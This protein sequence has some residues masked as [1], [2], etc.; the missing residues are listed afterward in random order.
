[1]ARRLT[2]DGHVVRVFV[3]GT[4]D[5][6]VPR[7]L[8]A[9]DVDFE[10]IP[11]MGRS[12]N[13][14]NDLLAL[15]S[16]RRKV[17]EFSPDL[18]STHASKAGALGRIACAG[19]RVPVL[20]TP[21]CWS[22]T[23]GFPN[24]GIYLWIERLLAPLASR[25]ITV[26]E[27]ERE[28]GLDRGVGKATR[29]IC[30]HN[31]V[32]DFAERT[33]RAAERRAGSILM[34]A[35]FE[36]QKDQQLLLRAMA[37]NSD[38]NWNLT[39]VGDGPHRKECENLA[40][41]LD[42]D[43]RVT[44]AG[45]SDQVEEYLGRC[46]IFALITHWEGFPRSILEAMRAGLPVVVSNVGGCRESVSDGKTGRV[47]RHGDQQELAAAIRELLTDDERREAMG[48]HALQQYQERFTFEVMYQKY[49]DLYR[50][51]CHA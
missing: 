26:C 32:V 43:A 19:L 22:F 20:Y 4:P 37:E 42:I 10:C 48:A 8:A 21:H 36:E 27:Q 50:S 51:V 16:L 2:D 25:I 18:V 15:R 1:M 39:F 9:K 33:G 40:R 49:V 41:S 28:F 23:D 5:M 45:Y 17:K 46:A 7:R 29:T 35:R 24:A 31:G 11:H 30:I 38:L 12:I 44:F 6:E 3:G 14:K 47:V 13:P 34:V